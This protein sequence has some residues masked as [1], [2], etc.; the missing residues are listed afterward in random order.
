MPT[1]SEFPER[2]R[3]N[4]ESR[5]DQSH[6]ALARM[7]DWLGV[8]VKQCRLKTV[9][10]TAELPEN[11]GL[12]WTAVDLPV[13]KTA[14]KPPRETSRRGPAVAH[15]GAETA[16]AD[17]RRRP[18]ARFRSSAAAVPRCGAAP[19]PARPASCDWPPTPEPVSC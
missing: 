8:R 10:D 14:T 13:F 4:R 16:S 5:S 1:W 18:A 12:R 3:T 11:S 7:T 2:T 6:A 17:R 15:D 19:M 9:V